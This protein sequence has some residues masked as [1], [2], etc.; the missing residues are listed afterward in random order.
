MMP[1]DYWVDCEH[2][3]C[4]GVL[5][6]RTLHPMGRIKDLWRTRD[7]GF[8]PPFRM[9][10]YFSLARDWFIDVGEIPLVT[11]TTSGNTPSHL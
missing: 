3:M 11:Q 9:R 7:D 1:I 5:Y 6:G 8:V 4:L 2:L 10:E